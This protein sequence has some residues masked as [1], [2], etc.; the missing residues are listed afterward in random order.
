MKPLIQRPIKLVNTCEA[1]YK[2]DLL[3]KAMLWFASDPMEQNKK[4]FM[5]GKYPA[6]SIG[7]KKLHIHRLIASFLW[8]G[9]PRN[10]YVHHIDENKL[11][12][13]QDNL[14]LMS[15]SDHQRLTNRG[16]K[17]T[18]E[19]IEKRITKTANAKRGRKYP[20]SMRTQS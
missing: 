8:G 3:I 2:E 16:R 18:K 17:Q 10:S 15:A 11:N 4:V 9:L 1:V 6:V 13:L 12:A 20:K 5:F 14:G 19:W 7:K